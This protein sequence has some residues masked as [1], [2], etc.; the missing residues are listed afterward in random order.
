[1]NIQI[2]WRN[3]WR[4][5]KRTAITISSVTLAVV[6]AI[7]MRSFQEGTYDVMIENAV[8]KF[9]G[10]VQVHQKDYWDD[11]TIDNGIDITDKL[12][13]EIESVKGV[14]GTNLRIESFSLASYKMNRVVM[15]SERVLVTRGH[16][17]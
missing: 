13:R 17:M 2:A 7:F 6:L 3:I 16:L 5:K 14:E 8:G 11:K 4:N 9:S 10:Y 1:M 12:I 15:K